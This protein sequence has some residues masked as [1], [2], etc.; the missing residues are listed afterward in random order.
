MFASGVIVYNT[1]MSEQDPALATANPSVQRSA[2]AGSRPMRWRAPVIIL[3]LAAV[4]IVI[5][6]T[7]EALEANFRWMGTALAVVVATLSLLVWFVFFTPFRWRTRLCVVGGVILVLFTASRVLRYDGSLDGTAF[8]RFAWKWTPRKSGDVGPV[9]TGAASTQPAANETAASRDFPGFLGAKRDGVIEGV[10]LAR[11]WAAQPP[12]LLW[13]QPMGLGYTGFAVSGWRAITLEQRG[14]KELVTCYAL[15]TGRMLW[16]YAHAD[17]FVE[18]TSGDGPRSTPEIVED[19]VYTLG[20]TGILDCL[21]LADGKLLWSHNILTENHAGNLTFGKSC[22]P[23]VAGEL[24]YVT[25]GGD[26]GPSLL[27]YKRTDGTLAWT[28]GNHAAG[29]GSPALVTLGGVPQII[30]IGGG[31]VESHDP[32]DGHSLWEYKWDGADKAIMASQPVVVGPDSVYLSAGFGASCTLLKIT[33]LGDGKFT[34]SEAWKNKRLKTDFSTAIARDGFAYGLDD[35][36]LACIDL[37][38]GERKWKGGHYERG[39]VLLAGDLL[40]VQSEPG[41]VF[42]VEANPAAFHELGHV[43]ALKG[44]TWNNPALAGEYLVVRNDQEAACYKLAFEKS[45]VTR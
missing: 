31:Y 23:L 43:D 8:P 35:G 2:G 33:A 11:D 15:T 9:Q 19:R 45:V 6:R 22:S 38:T 42:L 5:V 1:G 24:V 44:K 41:P 14:D 32:T 17:R 13:R 18:K 25:G 29:Y 39:Q 34:V 10:R 4:A 3:A 40:L 20:A 37:A 27:A 7:S 21:A 36:V 26:K 28:A 30:V 16:S 12:Q